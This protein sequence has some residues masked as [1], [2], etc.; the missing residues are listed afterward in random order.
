MALLQLSMIPLG[1]GISVGRYVSLIQKS[2]EQQKANFYLTDM[3]TIIEGDIQDLFSLIAKIY[4]IPFE[5]GAVRVVTQI[6]IDDRR[7][8]EVHIGDKIE[9]VN[10][11]NT[12]IQK[13]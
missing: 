4:E 10:Q 7:D 2:L 11:R 5:H 1:D 13:Q 12:T 6:T 8:K 3:S 9:S